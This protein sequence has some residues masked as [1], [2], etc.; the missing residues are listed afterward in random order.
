MK[1][2][3]VFVSLLCTLSIL[4]AA[5][6]SA[7]EQGTIV[8]MR[9]TE[10]MGSQ[11]AFMN[12]MSGTANVQTSEVCPEYV[13]VT[14]KV[15]YVIIGKSSDQ[16]LPL[17]EST[18]FHLQKNEVLIRVDDARRES[19]FHVKEMVLRPEWDRAQQIVEAEAMA[20]M[21]SHME[22]AAMVQGRQ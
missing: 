18:R 20:V 7:H 13:L 21:H 16:L 12:A 15:V 1:R 6:N 3:L 8:R 10:C 11:H 4:V 19:R 2:A 5:E 17:A 22:S 9:M 14:G